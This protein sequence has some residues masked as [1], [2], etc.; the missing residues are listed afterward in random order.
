MEEGLHP[1]PPLNFL[2]KKNSEGGGGIGPIAAALLVS[3]AVVFQGMVVSV[4]W[5]CW[6]WYGLVATVIEHCGCVEAIQTPLSQTI[7]RKSNVLKRKYTQK[8]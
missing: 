8:M 4:L 6:F 2:K 7:K 5:Y 1:S 3:L